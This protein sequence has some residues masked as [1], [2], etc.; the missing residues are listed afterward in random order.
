M[1][2]LDQV[3]C[4]SLRLFP[5]A[6]RTDRTCTKNCD[7]GPYH[8]IK[9]DIVNISIVGVHY[10]EEFWPEPTKFDP[11][12]FAPENKDNIVPY[13]YMPFGVGPR[14]CIGMRLANLEAKIAV[15]QII[16]H[17]KIKRC[18]KTEV[19]IQLRKVGLTMPVNGI[20]VRLEK[21]Q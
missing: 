1:T 13:S 21:R 9:G 6:M 17:F 2:Y 3:F 11:D 14:N 19:P 16:K 18:E 7:V 20:W 10:D 4:E 8:F 12:R 5:P 15:A